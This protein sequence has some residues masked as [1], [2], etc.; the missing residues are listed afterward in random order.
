LQYGDHGVRLSVCGIP[1]SVRLIY[2]NNIGKYIGEKYFVVINFYFG[3]F[4]G[5]VLLLHPDPGSDFN[6]A[7]GTEI[8]EIP[9]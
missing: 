6:P 5:I 4:I 1:F 2:E 9:F 3:H 7:G 8:K